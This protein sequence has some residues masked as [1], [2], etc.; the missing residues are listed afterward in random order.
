[1][2]RLVETTPLNPYAL[3]YSLI[4]GKLKSHFVR[5]GS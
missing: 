1:M 3:F 2:K 5:A 4:S